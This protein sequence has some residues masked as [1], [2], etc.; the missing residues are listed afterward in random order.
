MQVTN[1]YINGSRVLTQDE[2]ILG[3]EIKLSLERDFTYSC[4]DTKM[5]IE[6]KFYC[7]SGKNEID[8]AYEEKGIDADGEIEIVDDCGTRSQTF[9]FKLDFKS[10]KSNSNFTTLGIIDTNSDWKQTLDEDVNVADLSGAIQDFYVRNLPLVYLYSVSDF[11]VTESFQN[12]REDIIW[13]PIPP[14]SIDRFFIFPKGKSSINELEDGTE[15]NYNTIVGGDSYSYMS[16]T[17]SVIISSDGIFPTS[18]STSIL[19]VIEI[20]PIFKNMLDDGIITITTSGANGMSLNLI[21]TTYSFQYIGLRE[22]IIIGEDYNNPRIA[23]ACQMS[24]GSMGSV[25]NSFTT[26]NYSANYATGT[27]TENYHTTYNGITG[28]V[29]NIK[30]GEKLWHYYSFRSGYSSLTSA[31]IINGVVYSPST[32]VRFINYKKIEIEINRVLTIDFEVTKNIKDTIVGTA[33]IELFHTK[34]KA[35][36]GASLL[37]SVFG[38]TY[39]LCNTDCYSDLW[40]SRG[41]YLR[42][43]TDVSN[44]IVK[45]KQFFSELEK[46]V[47]CGLGYFYNTNVAPEKRLMSVYDFYTDNIVP[48]QYRFEWEDIIDGE[49]ILAPFL[50][51]YYKEIQIG[52]NNSKDSRLD[53]CK[54]N[55]YT[56]KN[57]SDSVYSKVSDFIASMYL[58]TKALRLGTSVEDKEYDN[59]IFILSG[60]T[61]GTSPAYNATLSQSSGFLT[62]NIQTSNSLTNGINRRYATV[63]NLFR[64]LYKWGF[65]LF[66]DRENMVVNKYDGT[67]TYNIKLRD[68]TVGTTNPNY[69]GLTDCKTTNYLANADLSLEDLYT[70]T[71]QQGLYVPTEIT[72]R[73]AKLSTFDLIEMRAI[74]YDLFP[75]NADGKVYYGNLISANLVDDVTEIKLLRRFKNGI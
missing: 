52:Y 21:D 50:T 40:F 35:Y 41:D 63:F 42:G 16:P 31:I 13:S 72:F 25:I 28:E 1:L 61:V 44:F 75:V 34:T 29:L 32:V 73:T 53:F 49:I 3:D 70:N 39:N 18:F 36:L 8:F 74:Q 43:K 71:I 24:G 68:I 66:P 5:D 51:P 7:A 19:S 62:D 69:Q 12:T 6:V 38:T 33:D 10:Y 2:P 57:K 9:T 26:T 4:I 67:S 37:N 14:I 64:H 27:H 60:A 48:S 11:E 45:P 56:L 65:S 58:I 55:N 59:N 15:P 47:C 54:Q 30:K 23:M 46:V 22:H 20:D 17:N